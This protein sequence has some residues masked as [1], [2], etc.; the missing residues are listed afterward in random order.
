MG[1]VLSVKLKTGLT[2]DQ[3]PDLIEAWCSSNC[4]QT[5]EMTE[6]CETQSCI[7][8]NE[9]SVTVCECIISWTKCL[10]LLTRFS[11]DQRKKGQNWSLDLFGA[12]LM[13]TEYMKENV[14]YRNLPNHEPWLIAASCL[15]FN[16]LVIRILQENGR[17]KREREL[18]LGA[19]NLCFRKVSWYLDCEVRCSCFSSQSLSFNPKKSPWRIMNYLKCSWTIEGTWIFR[20]VQFK[21]KSLKWCSFPIFTS[22]VRAG[23]Y[24]VSEEFAKSSGCVSFWMY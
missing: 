19:S 8:L 1:K 6:V 21:P 16:A 17:L 24:F 7:C 15:L 12:H 14:K 22:V 3:S 20:S 5:L 10:T 11:L 23:L 13:W 18:C 4:S 2:G 9:R